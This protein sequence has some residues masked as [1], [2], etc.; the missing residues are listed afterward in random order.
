MIIDFS[1]AVFS[2]LIWTT[3]IAF[4]ERVTVRDTVISSFIT[5]VFVFFCTYF[6]IFVFSA[7]SI[8]FFPYAASVWIFFSFSFIG[9]NLSLE[10]S[11]NSAIAY[12]LAILSL[13]S[14]LG[15]LLIVVHHSLASIIIATDGDVFPVVHFFIII[16]CFFRFFFPTRLFLL[17]CNF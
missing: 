17:R 6:L 16:Y 12:T 11:N 10:F 7:S 9:L 5:F 2:A 15:F 1:F 3:G 13:V 8:D 14:A 4:L